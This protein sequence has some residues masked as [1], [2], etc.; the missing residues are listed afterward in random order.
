[1]DDQDY[2]TK[3]DYCRNISDACENENKEKRITKAVDI[4]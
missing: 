2:E 4:K 1:M 3:S